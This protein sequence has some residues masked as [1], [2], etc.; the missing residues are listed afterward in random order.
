[1]KPEMQ[2]AVWQEYGLE[3]LCSL[4]MQISCI[5]KT[6]LGSVSQSYRHHFHLL[7]DDSMKAQQYGLVDGWLR[8]DQV[9]HDQASI[10]YPEAEQSFFSNGEYLSAEN[11]TALLQSPKG[12]CFDSPVGLCQRL[13][14]AVLSAMDSS[15]TIAFA[16]SYEK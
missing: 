5:F 15:N 11:S 6:C 9:D 10:Q 8:T 3:H 13:H 4:F 16:R 2:E 7:M 14:A 12:L 1:M